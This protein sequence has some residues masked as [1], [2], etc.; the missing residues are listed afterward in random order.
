MFIEETMLR[1][2]FAAALSSW[3]EDSTRPRSA[4]PH[5][6][7]HHRDSRTDAPTRT[8]VLDLHLSVWDDRLDDPTSASRREG[9]PISS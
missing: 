3:Q 4:R 8:D 1:V 6:R 2:L 9:Y 5:L 7:S